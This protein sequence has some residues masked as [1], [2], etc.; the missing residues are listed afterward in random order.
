MISVKLYLLDNY[1]NMVPLVAGAYQV[2]KCLLHS[3]GTGL[4][5][6]ISTRSYLDA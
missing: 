1:F 4:L 3:L 6:S 5:L 2:S